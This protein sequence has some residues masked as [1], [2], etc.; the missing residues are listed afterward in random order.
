MK[1]AKRASE[2][3]CAYRMYEIKAGHYRLMEDKYE[4][5]DVAERYDVHRDTVYRGVRRGDPLYPD[6]VLLGNGPRPRLMVMREALKACDTRRIAF[7]KT[8]PSWLKL[9][10]LDDVKPPTRLSARM[11][12]APMHNLRHRAPPSPIGLTSL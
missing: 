5:V 6:A 2:R 4:L 12:L 11:L 9:D 1:Q 10:G 8:T 3:R 7:Y